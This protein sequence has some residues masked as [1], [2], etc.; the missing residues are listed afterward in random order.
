MIDGVSS[1]LAKNKKY[2]VDLIGRLFK[3]SEYHDIV[4][5]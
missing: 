4:P 3:S 1:S 2:H 5:V